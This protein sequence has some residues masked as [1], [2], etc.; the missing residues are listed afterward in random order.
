M[1]EAKLTLQNRITSIFVITSL[2]FISV[3]TFIQL[4]NEMQSINRYNTYRSQLSGMIVK[5][6]LEEAMAGSPESLLA[7]N[8]QKTIITLREN[9]LVKN[10][11]VFNENGMAIASTKSSLFGENASSEELS[12]I[13]G[14]KNLSPGQLF[15]INLAKDSGTF[16][17]YMPIEAASPAGRHLT[18]RMA[19]PLAGIQQALAEVYKPI[20][21]S[22]LLIILANII[23]AFLLSKTVIG[24]IGVL[25]KVT[26][27]IASGDL[28]IRVSI[29]TGDE[30]QELGETFN[31]MTEELIKMKERAENANPLTK[32]PGNIVI[33]EQIE[34]RIREQEKFTVIYC[35]LDNFK[36][37]NDKYG[38]GEGDKAIKL[39][40]E[41]FKEALAQNGG[42]GDFLG[43]EG[44]DDFLLITSVDKAEGIAGF[45]ISEF[46]KRVRL[47][48]AEEDLKQGFIIAHGRDGAI[49]KFPLMT[50]SLA[51]VSNMVRPISSYAQVTN[52]AA[53]LKKKAKAVES[54]VYVEDKRTS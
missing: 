15:S 18:V 20:I 12:K 41:I 39:T 28:A 21:I 46:D 23:F 2:L 35:D 54:S 50:I 8:L 6:S 43:H 10:I 45:I 7:E 11:V 22:A 1:A 24:P 53:E 26:K 49:K 42:P 31:Y 30:L 16:E 38:I 52:T 51:G 34:R 9:S 4:N 14:S 5:A 17:A 27:K 19:F 29:L 3:F 48:Y 32:L 25:N 47:L 33:H 36:A 40:A 37:F 44:G 13:E